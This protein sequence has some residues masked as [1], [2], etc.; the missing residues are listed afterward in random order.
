VL[1]ASPFESNSEELSSVA[2]LLVSGVNHR[3]S[4]KKKIPD[5]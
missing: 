3:N 4:R 1:V 2:A 5:F